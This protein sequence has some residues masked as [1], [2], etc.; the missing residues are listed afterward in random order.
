MKNIHFS[1]AAILIA[2]FAF[3]MA[4][5]RTDSSPREAEDQVNQAEKEI[6][7]EAVVQKLIDQIDREVSILENNNY[8]VISSKGEDSNECR[9]VVTVTTPPD[10]KFPKTITLDYG[11]GC[12]DINKN[13][14]A[15]QVIVHITGPYWEKNTV[16]QAKLVDYIFNDMKI[17]GNRHEMNKGRNDKGNYVFEVK[18]I[19]KVW[20]E[21]GELVVERNIDRTREYS[22]GSDLKDNSDDEVW[23][24]GSAKVNISGR[25]LLKEI[26]EPLHRKISCQHFQSGIIV[27]Y[28]DRKKTG[29]MN[30]FTENGACDDVAVWTNREGIQKK[31]RLSPWINPYSVKP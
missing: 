17:A 6:A 14:R 25:N 5:T 19:E 20:D 13:F 4:C 1:R 24:T 28:E 8:T 16:R 18:Q 30:Y 10:S 12:L 21:M 31:I 22:R 9:P 23:V 3:I 27:T 2:A 11:E 29:E 26:T 7:V 15:G